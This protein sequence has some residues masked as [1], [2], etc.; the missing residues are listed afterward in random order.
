MPGFLDEYGVK[1][2]QRE[3]RNRRLVIGGILAAIV[4]VLAFFY[5]RTW[6]QE[7]TVDRFLTLLQHQ[8]YQDAYRLWQTPDSAKYYPPEKFTEDWGPMGV[9]KTASTLHVDDVDYCGDGVVFNMRYPGADNF[10]LY[11]DRQTGKLS[12]APWS[13]C[14]GAHL[15]IWHFI[16]SR[17]GR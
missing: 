13:R 15:Q 9:Y 12:F 10:G 2:S 8:K 1:D 3:R 16:T 14:P 17:F 11:V 7:R 4:L 5:F 6:S